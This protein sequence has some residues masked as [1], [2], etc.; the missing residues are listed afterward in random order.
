MSTVLI[1][2]ANRGL[3]LEFVR[4]YA[5]AG[6]R[7]IA[8]C[9]TPAKADALIAIAAASGGRVTVHPLEMTE[10]SSIRAFKSVIADQPIDIAIANAGIYGGNRQGWDDMDFDAWTR[11]F[12]V[13]TMAPLRLA[14]IVHGN[15][16]AGDGKIFV[17][18]TS[19]MGSNT[20]SSAGMH[21]YRTSKAA[22]NKLVSTL[23][24][25]WKADDII[26][27]PVHPGW[28]RTDMGGP[29]A[30]LSPEDSVNAMRTTISAL[31]PSDSG[32]FLNYDGTGLPW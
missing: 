17:A 16:K 26:A 30:P 1:A 24:Q 4:Q 23:A 11:T 7:V 32:R 31:K 18:I 12:A 21:A 20:G 15:L 13:N 14:Q 3:G 10:D 25:E 2:G 8:T 19:Q 28:V 29:S 5:A 6:D 27:V 22:L 9:R